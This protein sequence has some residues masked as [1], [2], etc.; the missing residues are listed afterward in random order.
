MKNPLIIL[1]E[2]F[3]SKLASAP[4]T[5]AVFIEFCYDHVNEDYPVVYQDELVA[6]ETQRFPTLESRKLNKA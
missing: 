3:R 1:S 2:S 6:H 5:E 4:L